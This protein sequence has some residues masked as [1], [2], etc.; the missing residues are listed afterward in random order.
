MGWGTTEQDAYL[1]VN[2]RSAQ[3]L[4]NDYDLYIV[5]DPQPR[6]YVTLRDREMPNGSGA[7]TSTVRRR[8]RRSAGFCAP[9]WKS[10]WKSVVFT[11]SQEHLSCR[12]VGGEASG[13][14]RPG[15]RSVGHEHGVAD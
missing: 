4:G 13:V 6:P 11:M 12:R 1:K 10:I 5:H 9:C 8:T 14:H 2:E 15:N 3:A 7:A